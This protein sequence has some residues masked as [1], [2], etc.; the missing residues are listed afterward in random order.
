MEHLENVPHRTAHGR[1]PLP[2]GK[3]WSFYI[4]VGSGVGDGNHPGATAPPLL[5]QEGSP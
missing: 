1:E 4:H 5:I 3:G 2:L